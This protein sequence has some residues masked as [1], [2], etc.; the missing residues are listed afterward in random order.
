[1]L[2]FSCLGFLVFTVFFSFLV[3]F[4]RCAFSPLARLSNH[5]LY[6]SFVLFSMISIREF[7]HGLCL[8]SSFLFLEL[9]C[10]F[11]YLPICFLVS[12][13]VSI[14]ICVMS[15]PSWSTIFLLGFV[16]VL[17]LF[18]CCCSCCMS[19]CSCLVFKCLRLFS[20]TSLRFLSIIKPCHPTFFVLA[21][22]SSC[23]FLFLSSLVLCTYAIVNHSLIYLLIYLF[24]HS[25]TPFVPLPIYS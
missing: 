20:L 3:V 25:F 9:L 10:C 6:V 17:F 2:S 4:F 23:L 7:Q 1:M 24:I 12:L 13:L 5:F 8:L 19:F 14:V 21:L 16:S 18:C 15:L 22:V 11:S